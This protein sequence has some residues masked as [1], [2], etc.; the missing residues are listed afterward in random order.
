MSID[1]LIAAL[2]DITKD[3]ARKHDGYEMKNL[4]RSS[5]LKTQTTPI[6]QEFDQLLSRKGMSLLLEQWCLVKDHSYK[7]IPNDGKYIVRNVNSSKE[8]TVLITEC[9][10]CTCKEFS[11]FDMICRH[12]L[13]V[14]NSDLEVFKGQFQTFVNSV[15]NRW[16]KVK[17]ASSNLTQVK[18]KNLFESINYSNEN[19]IMAKK[20][21]PKYQEEKFN[22]YNPILQGLAEFLD[23]LSSV[24]FD[25]SLP[26]LVESIETFK[27]NVFKKDSKKIPIKK[28]NSKWGFVE[29]RANKATGRPRGKRGFLKFNKSKYDISN[30]KSK[31]ISKVKNAKNKL[32]SKRKPSTSPQITKSDSLIK[33]VDSKADDT[34][35]D[36]AGLDFDISAAIQESNER[37]ADEMLEKMGLSKKLI[38]K[39][40]TKKPKSIIKTNSDVYHLETL[41]PLKSKE[42]HFYKDRYV[43]T[44][45]TLLGKTNWLTASQ[46][47][48]GMQLIQEQFQN[49]NILTA[50]PFLNYNA[51]Q[52]SLDNLLLDTKGNHVIRDRTFFI[53]HSLGH[54]WVNMFYYLVNEID[55]I[56]T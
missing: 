2:I 30:L 1:Q 14:F 55:E 20:R 53:L 48:Y 11:H 13:V 4:C 26:L 18:A 21:K 52:F 8:S 56:I 45:V 3:Y 47:S 37:R 22:K 15:N 36:L 35:K 9:I 49:V 43:I 34:S 5:N 39:P 31:A 33:N 17:G 32:F 25:K 12:M 24:K 50:S 38:K 6:L 27:A 23:K 16:N 7:I 46:V 41:M 51:T 29:P 54:H 10:S 19:K 44:D 40:P 42:R 28:K